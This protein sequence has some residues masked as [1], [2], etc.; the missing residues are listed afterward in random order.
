[1][2]KERRA[3]RLCWSFPPLRGPLRANSAPRTVPRSHRIGPELLLGALLLGACS[4]P[5]P[6]SNPT[7]PESGTRVYHVQLQLTEEKDQ[8]VETLNQAL[9]W[10]KRQPAS[11]RPPLVRNSQ[12]SE[13]PV[14]IKW[15]APLYRVRLGP[16]ASEEQAE[17]VLDAARSA[18][19]EAFVA[20]DRLEAL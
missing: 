8:A 15:K 9:R 10:W 12:S 19:P 5:G 16:F 13:P 3:D 6:A 1:M 14:S 11:E 18:F 20:P 2:T 17:T 4:A 7:N